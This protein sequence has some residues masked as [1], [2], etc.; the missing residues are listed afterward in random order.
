MTAYWMARS[1]IIDPIEY[2]KYTEKVPG[3]IAEYGGRALARGGKHEILEG[4]EDHNRFVVIEFPS[5]KLARECFESQAYREAAAFR[6]DGAGEVEIAIV[7][8]LDGKTEDKA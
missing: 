2:S 7:E 1:K 6:R 4:G 3:I 8:G 5:L